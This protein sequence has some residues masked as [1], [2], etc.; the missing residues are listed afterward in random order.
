MSSYRRTRL[1]VP[2]KPDGSTSF[3]ARQK[4]GVYL[5][6]R[7]PFI[8]E[9][10][11]RYVGY[12]GVDVYKALYRH[13]QTWNDKQAARGERPER[14]T[15]SPPGSYRVRVIYTRKK[16]EAAELERALIIKHQPPDNPDKLELYTLT[17]AGSAMVT[18]S[19]SA[20]FVED[21]EAPF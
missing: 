14:I 12:S 20:P 21:I 5:I 11:L 6:Y 3:P 10:R 15:Y 17:K 8:G 18:A 16:S 2:Y 4:R 1:L 19:S 7:V 9:P 13:F